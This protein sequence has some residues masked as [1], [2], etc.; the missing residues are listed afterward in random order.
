MTWMGGKRKRDLQSPTRET[1]KKGRSDTTPGSSSNTASDPEELEPSPEELEEMMLLLDQATQNPTEG[2]EE[3][4]EEEEEEEDRPHSNL[5]PTPPTP[6]IN[7]MGYSPSFPPPPPPGTTSSPAPTPSLD[8]PE[9]HSFLQVFLGYATVEYQT[10]PLH[11]RMAT[12]FADAAERCATAYQTNPTAKELFHFLILPKA[13]LVLGKNN[14]QGLN[15]GEVLREFPQSAITPP[16]PTGSMPKSSQTT[17]VAPRVE[18]L[19]R[20]GHLSKAAR[21]LLSDDQISTIDGSKL[22]QLANKHPPGPKNP[23]HSRRNPK[24]GY[25]PSEEDI[26]EAIRKTNP[27]TNPGIG[28][29]TKELLEIATKRPAVLRFLTQLGRQLIQGTAPGQELLTASLLTALDKKDEQGGVR[30]I[31][32][33]E[34]IYR[35]LSKA[36][37]KINKSNTALLKYQLGV[38]SPGGTEPAIRLMQRVCFGDLGDKYKHITKLDFK[39]AFNSVDRRAIATGIAKHNPELYRMSKWLYDTP[40]TLAI[41]SERGL[42]RI[43]SSQGVRQGDPMGPLLFSVAIRDTVQELHNYLKLRLNEKI[44]ITAYLDDIQVYSTSADI[45]GITQNFLSKA[46]SPLE[47]NESKSRTYTVQEI[48]ESGIEALGTMVGPTKARQQFLQNKVEDLEEALSKLK[49][50]PRQMGF[51]ILRSCI[52]Q[53]LR[54]LLRSLDPTGLTEIWERVD[55]A[56]LTTIRE[57]RNNKEENPWD[58][59]VAAL[60]LKKGGLGLAPHAELAPEAYRASNQAADSFLAGIGYPPQDLTPTPPPSPE[61]TGEP[62]PDNPLTDS[63]QESDPETDQ[64]YH[65]PPPSHQEATKNIQKRK[66]RELLQLISTPMKRALVEN[67]SFLG[68]HWLTV[69]PTTKHHT[70][71]DSEFSEALS[72]RMLLDSKAQQGSSCLKCGEP[73][74]FLHHQACRK[75]VKGTTSR[76]DFIKKALSKAYKSVPGNQV[77]EEVALPGGSLRTDIRVVSISGTVQHYDLTIVSIHGSSTNKKDP[78]EALRSIAQEKTNKY[79]QLGTEFK[80]LVISVG[81]LM[82]KETAGGYKKLQN[83]LRGSS[84]YLDGLIS[85]SLA[86]SRARPLL[87]E[88]EE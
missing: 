67:S 19:I 1:S 31:A 17:T 73:Q 18:K 79:K 27:E 75:S 88:W 72:Q 10:E 49:Q 2:P 66:E 36:I 35:C 4:E 69:L 22:L 74:C 56:V 13:G 84:R 42:E 70:L 3:E 80:P 52:Q 14:N 47:L 59:A 55:K 34:L 38:G 77:Q 32:M 37:L 86:S 40:S 82:E 50:L 54:H 87:R 58:Q 7:P 78:L 53:Q 43:C 68:S 26:K 20:R 65:Q 16:P 28:G 11:G 12:L 45:I 9:Q 71:A 51:L 83:Q 60:P 5:E 6:P 33:G 81:G 41:R 44:A 24:A 48:R 8:L 21:V 23:F 30:P 85:V 61:G 62:P 63:P 15:Q 29:W 76:H 64:G 39:N 57:L 46:N 25:A